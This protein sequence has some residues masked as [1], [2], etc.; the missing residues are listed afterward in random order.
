MVTGQ[1]P[2]IVS[3]MVVGATSIK[4]MMRFLCQQ[5]VGWDNSAKS[6]PNESE[7]IIRIESGDFSWR[8]TIKSLQEEVGTKD[9]EETVFELKDINISIKRG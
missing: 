8:K 1:I 5:D 2:V 3:T 6:I 9:D 4:R 7:E